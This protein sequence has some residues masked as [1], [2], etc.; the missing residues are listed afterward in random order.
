MGQVLRHSV[1]EWYRNESH[2]VH[3]DTMDRT[4]AYTVLKT[5]RLEED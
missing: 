1:G 4:C 2:V 5:W 3:L